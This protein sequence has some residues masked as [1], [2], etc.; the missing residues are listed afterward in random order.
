MTWLHLLWV[1]PAGAAAVALVVVLSQARK[2][3]D[4]CVE[5]ARETRRLGE[6]RGPLVELRQ[7]MNRSEARTEG[8]WRHWDGEAGGRPGVT[9]S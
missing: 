9:R 1:V 2:L 8:I 4:L 6:L 5:L 7:E 3:E